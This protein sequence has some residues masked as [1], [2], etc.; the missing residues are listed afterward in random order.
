MDELAQMTDTNDVKESFR[1]LCLLYNY[2]YVAMGE[3][4]EQA[5][6]DR[7]VLNKMYVGTP[8]RRIEAQEILAII[9]RRT[10]IK[11]SLENVNVP[12]LPTFAELHSQLA[13]DLDAIAIKTGITFATIDK[14]LLGVK[15]V[16]YDAIQVLKYASHQGRLT[17]T[18][19]NTDV[20]VK[21]DGAKTS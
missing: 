17:F 18:L 5:R 1:D 15:V 2:R 13:F 16:K 4:A 6:V 8:V 3:I 14:M 12:L 19:E 9:A 21:D 10:G 11:Y 20:P 7:C